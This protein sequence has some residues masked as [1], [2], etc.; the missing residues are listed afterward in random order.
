MAA[1][2]LTIPLADEAA[3]TALAEDLAAILAPGDVIALSGG[4]GAGKTTLARALIRAVADDAALEV[5]S[6]TFTLVQG[7]ATARL[8]IAHFD[9]YRLGSPDE[10]DEIGLADA[11]GEGAVLIEWPERGEGRLPAE[12]LAVELAI[13]GDGRQAAL[14][15]GAAWQ[16]RIGRTRAARALIARGGLADA[17]RRYLQGDASIRRFERV[18]A[19]A[20]S[21]VLMD[22]PKPASPPLRDSRAAFRAREVDAFLAVGAGLAA[23][24]LSPPAIIAADR[25][26]GL[27]LMEDFGSEGVLVDGRPDPE[28]YAA[29]ID[30]LAAIHAAPRPAVLPVPG[31]GE[32]RLLPLLGAPLLADVAMFADWYV[33]HLTG[34]PLAAPAA[35]AFSAIWA[36][37]VARLAEAEPSWVLFDVQ[38]SN[39]FWLPE[40]PGVRRIGLIDFQDMFVGPA[41]YDVATL[42][43]DG[44][45]TVSPGLEADLRDRYVALR[46]AETPSFDAPSFAAAYAILGAARTLKNMGVFARLADHLGKPRYLQH[47]PRMQEYLARTFT[48]AVLSDL[49]VWYERHL[50]LPSQANR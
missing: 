35:E 16:E 43:L 46:R 20:R 27:L 26:A 4:L 25:A 48:H 8:T 5:P 2:F 11:V 28:R 49:A 47:L 33:P 38:S 14:S 22:W 41:A 12:R 34:A 1:P 24:G 23:I 9:L 31:G 21:A 17:Q 40:R 36:A 50:P 13:A 6:P 7:Y 44:R 10:V 45:V 42:C 15:A 39:L 3:T 18:H 29:V 19:G 32:H 30:V 37:L